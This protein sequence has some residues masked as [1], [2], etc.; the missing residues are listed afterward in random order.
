[1]ALMGIVIVRLNNGREIVGLFR[2]A[3]RTAHVGVEALR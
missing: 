2:A 3:V 1:M